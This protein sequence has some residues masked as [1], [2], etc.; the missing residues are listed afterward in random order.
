MCD[1]SLHHVASRPAKIECTLVRS[2]QVLHVAS[3][4]TISRRIVSAAQIEPRHK[5]GRNR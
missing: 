4:L 2:S 5:A 1:Y 3:L